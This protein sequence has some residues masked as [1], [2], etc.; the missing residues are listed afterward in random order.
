MP[1]IKR[2][3]TLKQLNNA[4]LGNSNLFNTIAMLMQERTVRKSIF[5]CKV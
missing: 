1:N 3:A 4:K 5:F 2:G